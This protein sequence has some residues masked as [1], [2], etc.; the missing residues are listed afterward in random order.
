M[1]QFRYCTPFMVNHLS[2]Q[3]FLY[4]NLSYSKS[5]SFRHTKTIALKKQQIPLKGDYILIDVKTT[6]VRATIDK[7]IA[8]ELHHVKNGKIVSHLSTLINPE[9][10]L[11]TQLEKQ[12]GVTN[13]MLQTAPAFS[14][15]A[16]KL[17]TFLKGKILIAHDARFAYAFI[18]NAF[19]AENMVLDEKIIC[20]LRLTRLLFPDLNNHRS[21]DLKKHLALDLTLT[22]GSFLVALFS[23]IV[24][25]I[26]PKDLMHAIDLLKKYPS[27][28]GALALQH[29]KHIPNTP[30]VYRF[31]GK[32]D[33]L[34]YVGK[35]LTLRESIFAHFIH[36]RSAKKSLKLSQQVKKIDWIKTVGEC[37]ALLL[38]AQLIKTKTPLFNQLQGRNATLY[39]IQAVTSQHHYMMLEVVSLS[40]VET[41]NIQHVYGIFKLRQQA[42]AKLKAF[43]NENNLCYSINQFGKALKPC[44][45]HQIQKCIGACA[46]TETSDSYNARILP[47]LKNLG[48]NPWPFENRIA[49]KESCLKNKEKAEFHI[50]DK[51]HY[52]GTVK[53]LDEANE[54]AFDE[55]RIDI[56]TFNI[57]R[58]FVTQKLDHIGLIKLKGLTRRH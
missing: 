41:A 3:H 12:T 43:I 20:T 38:E 31:Y 15:M 2:M 4:Y 11:S 55:S 18:K 23:Q 26:S 9:M 16:K 40:E 45:R 17:H 10:T 5:H 14:Q 54:N 49:I 56:D 32:N 36:D 29:T 21:I 8:I 25:V 19:K 24:K 28:P 53:Q 33:E 13:E 7:I 22:D 48:P 44:F 27:M 52:L 58:H 39:T 37:G 6:G 30:G 34:L 46:H 47:H 51:W 57:V 42:A 35:S 50:I 1:L